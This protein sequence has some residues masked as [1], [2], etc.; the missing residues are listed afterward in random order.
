MR[1]LPQLLVVAALAV[2]AVPVAARFLPASHPLLDR[3]GLLG[4]VAALGLVP[5]AGDAAGEVPEDAAGA[6]S[7]GGPGGGR[8]TV[9]VAGPA[10]RQAMRDVITAIGSGRGNQ[11]VALAPDVT[12]RLLALRVRAGDRVEA[13]DIIAE[14][15]A[16][17]AQLALERADL[18]LADAR[19]RL[20]RIDRLAGTGAATVLQRQDAELALR[21]AELARQEAARNLADHRLTAPIAGIV[22]LIGV[23][24]GDLLTPT[25]EVTRIEDRSSLI[26]EFRVPERLAALVQPGATVTAS[27]VSGA[28]YSAEGPVIAV[29]NRV[30]EV[31]RTLR[32]QARI[33]NADDT[34]RAGMAFRVTLEFTGAEYPAVDPLAI[35]W[36]AEGAFIWVVRD[37]RAMELPIHI[38]QR[39]ADEVLVEA[40]FAPGDLVVTEGVQA[41]R[42]GAQVRIAPDG[43]DG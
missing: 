41:L 15:D 26:V 12:G 27:A 13:G 11:T 10:G 17:T 28:Q 5:G 20:D 33:D 38:L 6:G 21:T 35:Q 22:G 2:L 1:V 3:M 16:E 42:P 24:V 31:S 32:V 39:N 14:L 23:Q 25:T 18:V 30:D 37:D 29:D 19:A 9:V 7:A 4:P 36:G 40:A 8:A 34:L 43:G